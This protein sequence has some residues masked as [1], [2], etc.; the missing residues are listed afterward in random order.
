[1]AASSCFTGA[2]DRHDTARVCFSH[3]RRS[4]FCWNDDIR[5]RAAGGMTSGAGGPLLLEKHLKCNIFVIYHRLRP[6]TAVQYK[7]NVSWHPTI[8]DS[9]AERNSYAKT[10]AMAHHP[11]I[12]KCVF[13]VGLA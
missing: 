3:G 5:H 4:S 9:I 11:E 7:Q 10:K 1:M 2:V 13:S 8:V 12:S 6:C